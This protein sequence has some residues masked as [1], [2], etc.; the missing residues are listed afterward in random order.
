MKKFFLLLLVAFLTQFINAQVLNG[1]WEYFIEDIPYRVY[2]KGVVSFKNKDNRT[3]AQISLYYE[4][5]DV[6]LK[7][8][9]ESGYQASMYIDGSVVELVITSQEN[10]KLKGK[11]NIDGQDYAVTFKKKQ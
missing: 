2:E 5:Y 11:V 9:G 4:S 6:E 3:T 8:Q 10:N 1:T 7:K